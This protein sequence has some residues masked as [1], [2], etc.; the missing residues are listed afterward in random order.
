MKILRPGH[1]YDPFPPVDEATAEGLVAVGGDL[2]IDRLIDAYRLGIFPWF[3][4]GQPVLWWS[5]NPRAVLYPSKLHVSRSLRKT[6][7]QEAFTIR[8]DCA[9]REVMTACAAPRSGSLGTWITD[10]MIS[11]YG[12]L[13]ELGLAHSVEVWADQRLVGGLYGVALGGVFFGESMF[14]RV[15]D[16][17][18][19]A[20]VH[21]VSFLRQ[22]DVGLIDC[23]VTSPHL[24]SL[25]AEEIPRS[26]FLGELKSLDRPDRPGRW[27]RNLKNPTASNPG[28]DT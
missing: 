12:A 13:H 27:T 28:D 3:S 21:L 22:H 15:T 16:A 10:D 5:P 1:P 20:L 19:V 4:P 2:S 23:Q 14:S 17:S 7:R 18:K 25:G 6:I 11:A 26:R 24:L 9:F 8:F